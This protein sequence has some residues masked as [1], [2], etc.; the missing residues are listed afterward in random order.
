MVETV[1]ET[2]DRLPAGR[3]IAMVTIGHPEGLVEAQATG[4]S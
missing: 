4:A 3:V 2:L 1:E